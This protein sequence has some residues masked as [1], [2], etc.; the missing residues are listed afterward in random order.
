MGAF[1]TPDLKKA[2]KVAQDMGLSVTG[3]EIGSDGAIR[4]TI[5]AELDDS[6]EA[7]LARWEKKHG[8]DA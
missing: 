8:K 7:A 1:K 4:V 2:I 5:A 6:A 3:L